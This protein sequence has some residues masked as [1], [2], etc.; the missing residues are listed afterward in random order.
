LKLDRK[1]LKHYN[2]MVNALIKTSK[3]MKEIG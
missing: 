2:K 1:S 3:I